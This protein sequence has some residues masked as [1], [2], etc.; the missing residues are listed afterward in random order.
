MCAGQPNVLLGTQ[1]METPQQVLDC[2]VLT[3][4]ISTTAMLCLTGLR[5]VYM[6]LALAPHS[7]IASTMGT[8]SFVAMLM[9]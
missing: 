8:S 1:E 7:Y 3:L 9:S 6:L 5:H 2:C 4:R